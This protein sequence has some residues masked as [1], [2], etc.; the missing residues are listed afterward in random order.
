MSLLDDLISKDPKRIWEASCAIRTLRDPEQLATLSRSLNLIRSSTKGVYLGGMTRPNS[1]HLD[2]A[3][4]KLEFA[5][6]SDDCLC[7]L[8]LMDDLYDPK[9]EEREGNI[10][11]TETVNAD[12]GWIDHYICECSL[13][14]GRFRV[15]EREYHYT[16][17]S[18]KKLA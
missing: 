8:Y 5:A 11:I 3:I 6:S 12:G 2:F 9:G 10:L 16:W 14:D 7:T 13:C 15:E 17:W 4:R 18:W 1:S